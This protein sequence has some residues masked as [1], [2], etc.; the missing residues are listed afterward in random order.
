[1]AVTKAVKRGSRF[2]EVGVVRFATLSRQGE[3]AHRYTP[4]GE[5]LHD[6]WAGRSPGSQV[7]VRTGLP[8][9]PV[10]PWGCGLAAYSCG[11]SHSFD[12]VPLKPRRAPAKRYYAFFQDGLE[13]RRRYG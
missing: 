8:G 7:V 12:C 1:M 9:S 5:G 3:N 11:G 6:R 4:P 2:N 13:T 10:A